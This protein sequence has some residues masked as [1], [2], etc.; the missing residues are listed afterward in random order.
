V[1]K[2]AFAKSKNQALPIFYLAKNQ[3]HMNKAILILESFLKTKNEQSR[4]ALPK[5]A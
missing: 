4:F 5:T 1:E 2:E 3:K